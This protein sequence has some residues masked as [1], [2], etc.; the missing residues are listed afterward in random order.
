MEFPDYSG[1]FKPDSGFDPSNKNIFG[2]EFNPWSKENTGA[3]GPDFSKSSDD[4]FGETFKKWGQAADLANKW[5][6][7][8]NNSGFSGGGV[9]GGRVQG[10]G[11]LTV[12]YPDQQQPY[13]IQGSKGFGGALGTLAGIGASFIPGLG[14]GIAAA[15][16]AIGG[17]VGSFF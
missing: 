12:V 13:T 17:S 11:D 16:P 5:R 9:S 7:R 10:H 4:R 14:P 1:I 6:N 3:S 8:D 2:K 15:M